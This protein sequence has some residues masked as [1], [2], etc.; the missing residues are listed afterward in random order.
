M[1]SARRY[2]FGG[3]D[4][5]RYCALFYLPAM[6]PTLSF[7]IT[8]AAGAVINPAFPGL[9]VRGAANTVTLG[10]AEGTVAAFTFQ[11]TAEDGSN[12]APFVLRVRQTA[13]PTPLFPTIVS[14]SA[15]SSPSS[16]AIAASSG[17]APSSS[18]MAPATSSSGAPSA[19]SS[20][21]PQGCTT[22]SAVHA[23]QVASLAI[24]AVL[25]AVASVLQL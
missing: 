3:D 19:S 13:T 10:G 16:S 15:M 1:Y 21:G 25:V 2:G 6:A 8:P 17:A 24:V 12:F 5:N 9:S 20:T 14:S 18:A 23:T 4:T 22:C 7:T 11:I